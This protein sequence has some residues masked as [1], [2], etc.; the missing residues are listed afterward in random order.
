V[1]TYLLAPLTRVMTMMT[2][3]TPMTTPMSVRMVRSLLAPER[4][5][6][7]FEGLSEVHGPLSDYR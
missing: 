7:E 6:R 1:L 2:E 3:A 4:L 5:Q